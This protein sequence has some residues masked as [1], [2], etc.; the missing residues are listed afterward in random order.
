MDRRRPPRLLLDSVFSS[1]LQPSLPT[2]GAMK[3]LLK[4]LV[5]GVLLVVLLVVGFA[6]FLD[7][8]ARTAVEEGVTHATG[9]ETTL[10]SASIELVAGEVKFDSLEI[11]NPPGFSEQP[12]LAIGH[13]EADWDLGSLFGDEIVVNLLELDGLDLS[14][15]LNGTES[16]IGPL[17]ERLR[18][19]AASGGDAPGE[20]T[21]PS[22]EPSGEGEGGPDVFIDKVR[23]AGVR[24]GLKITGVPGIE[25]SYSAEVPEIIIEDLG[26]GEKS[27]TVAEWSARIVE[28]VLV[29]AQSAKG[30]FPAEYQALLAGDLDS[31]KEGLKKELEGE[32]KEL[33]EEQLGDEAKDALD[34]LKDKGLDG[35]LG[36]GD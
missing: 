19:L 8:M 4:L 3:L 15:E 24:T 31:L 13:F 20:P 35:I 22:G 36:G 5:A 27:G 23:I 32:V 25:G 17:I 14:L 28:V 29:A 34:K 16:N 21:E 30:N 9:S 6:F 11:A 2:L 12:M 1:R 26:T 7:P 33:I 18:E 10:E